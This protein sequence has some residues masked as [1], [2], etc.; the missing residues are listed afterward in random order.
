MASFCVVS[1]ELGVEVSCMQHKHF[2]FICFIL[3][4]DDSDPV[5]AFVGDLVHLC[6]LEG[7]HFLFFLV[8]SVFR[9]FS[10]LFLGSFGKFRRVFGIVRDWGHDCGDLCQR[11]PM[12]LPNS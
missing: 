2:F 11:S 1:S 3:F 5:S 4:L 12:L 9:P 10:R 8:F 6:T 7:G